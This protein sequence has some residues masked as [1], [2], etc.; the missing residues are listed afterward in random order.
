MSDKLYFFICCKTF[1]NVSY[2]WLNL[3]LN[4]SKSSENGCA[5]FCGSVLIYKLCV[6]LFIIILTK[7]SVYGHYKFR[8]CLF[9]A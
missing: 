5:S 8:K 7:L 3:V 1:Q 6:V 4:V 2:F 9:Y